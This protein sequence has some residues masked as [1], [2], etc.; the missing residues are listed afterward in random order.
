MCVLHVTRNDR[1]NAVILKLVQL[2]CLFLQRRKLANHDVKEL[3]QV[4]GI[5]RL[6]QHYESQF[7]TWHG[8]L[9][10]AK[11]FKNIFF[12][13]RVFL[14]GFNISHRIGFSLLFYGLGS[15]MQFLEDFLDK[16]VPDNAYRLIV[17]G[18]SPSVSAKYV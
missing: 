10:Y 7:E 15:K 9:R 12:D 6:M 17:N 8:E 11:H 3:P 16:T 1:V 4:D 2:H 18:S 5:Q 13:K 14:F